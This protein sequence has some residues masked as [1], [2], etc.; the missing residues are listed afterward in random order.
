MPRVEPPPEHITAYERAVCYYTLP[1]VGSPVSFGLI[2]I[3]AVC[4]FEAIGAMAI[5]FW[6]EHETWLRVGTYAFVG[7][8]LFGVAAFFVRAVLGKT[9]VA[10]ILR[11]AG[12]VPDAG[13]DDS[14]FPDPF[15]DHE[16]LRYP[17]HTESNIFAMTEDNGNI[18]YTVERA[19]SGEWWRIQTPED[20]EFCRVKAEGHFGSFFLRGEIPGPLAVHKAERLLARIE[21]RFAFQAPIALI[22][23]ENSDKTLTVRQRGIYNPEKRL[24][25]RIYYLRDGLYLDIEQ[26]YLDEGVL[27]YY[28]ALG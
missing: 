13:A 2:V 16:L 8:I 26:A 4:V 23:Y 5:G 9:R 22:R 10:R 7:I 18:R 14:D 27:G 24:V 28:A 17:R 25:G 20:K 19:E 21:P 11:E 6:F 15:A 1:K 12:Q 3:Y